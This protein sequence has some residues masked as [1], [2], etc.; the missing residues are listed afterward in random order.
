MKHII[1]SQI[2]FL[3][4]FLF[5]ANAEAVNSYYAFDAAGRILQ[6]NYGTNGM[7]QYSYDEVGNIT[8]IN[9]FAATAFVDTDSDG[10]DDNWEIFYFGSILI[11]D[12]NSN[13]DYD[14]YSDLEE[15]LFWLAETLDE[16]GSP[17][18]PIIYNYTQANI[19]LMITPILSVGR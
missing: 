10:M 2:L 15:Y 18:N 17:F 16:K 9:S 4:L 8:K 1:Q 11:A 6:C 13:F 5:H 19:L 3:S 14:G 12:G 7:I